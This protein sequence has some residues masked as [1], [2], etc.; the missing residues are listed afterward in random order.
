MSQ[1][2]LYNYIYHAR[3]DGCVWVAKWMFDYKCTYDYTNVI[4]ITVIIAKNKCFRSLPKFITYVD[5]VGQ[6]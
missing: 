4:R 1:L 3:N 6:G 5:I 2:V